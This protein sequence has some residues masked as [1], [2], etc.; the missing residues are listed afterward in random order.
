MKNAD[1][2][3]DQFVL[4]AHGMACLEAMAYGKPVLCY[5]K[6]SLIPQYPDDLPI[7]NANPDNLEIVLEELLL[8]GKKRCELGKQGRAYVEKY[9]D[10]MKLSYD[11]VSIYSKIIEKNRPNH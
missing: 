6:P 11:L 3:L 7:V 4:G 9:H 1:I 2:F 5:I 10:A 8:N